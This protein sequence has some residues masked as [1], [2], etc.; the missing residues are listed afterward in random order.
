MFLLFEEGLREMG[1]SKLMYVKKETNLRHTA[2]YLE[3]HLSKMNSVYPV[4]LIRSYKND[5]I[6]TNKSKC[7]FERN[8]LV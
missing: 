8:R 4:T 6:V 3:A 1:V 7:A 2:N 5:R